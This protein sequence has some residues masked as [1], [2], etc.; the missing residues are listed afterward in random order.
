MQPIYLAGHSRPVRKV[1]YNFDGDLL[2]TCSDDST[3]CMYNTFTYE[4]IAV[5]NTKEACKSFTLSKDSKYLIAACT[6]FGFLVFDTQKEA[7]IAEIAVPGDKTK[8][9]RQVQ[10]AVS[11][12]KFFVL[13]E[14][15]KKSHIV[16][17]DL[18]KVIKREDSAIEAH[19]DFSK[20]PSNIDELVTAA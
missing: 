14:S 9:V 18:Q 19:I 20:M 8:Q 16:I 6:T 4:R 3:V 11:D 17:Y 13:Y 5:F 10:F 12:Q 15:E 7:P 1:E 2:F